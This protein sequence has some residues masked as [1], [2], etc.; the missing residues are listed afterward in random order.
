MFLSLVSLVLAAAPTPN[1]DSNREFP[2]VGTEFATVEPHGGCT[3][4]HGCFAFEN[5]TGYWLSPGLAG[6]TGGRPGQAHVVNDE[7]VVSGVYVGNY[8]PAYGYPL[9]YDDVLG[10][11]VPGINHPKYGWLPA[12]DGNFYPAMEPQVTA[13]NPPRTYVTVDPGVTTVL[14]VQI[15]FRASGGQ[16]RMVYDVRKRIIVE[17]TPGK[18]TVV[19]SCSIFHDVEAPYTPQLAFMNDS[20][21]GH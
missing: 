15:Q 6:V 13:A 10:M 17:Y 7:G 21:C 20:E 4:P 18:G 9:F 5:R 2:F 3:V 12:V 8:G 1:W 11:P 14:A 16:T 19:H